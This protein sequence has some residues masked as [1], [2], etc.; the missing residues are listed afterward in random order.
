MSET[1]T[2]S[3]SDFSKIY[4]KYHQRYK[5][6]ALRYVR[7][8]SVAEDIVADSFLTFLENKDSLSTDDNI[9][10]YLFSIVRSK[11]L[12]YLRQEKRRLEI[13]KTIH[14]ARSLTIQDSIRS[15]ELCNPERLFSEEII[16]IV[17]K[18]LDTMP[19]LTRKIYLEIRHKEKTYKEVAKDNHITPRRVN[20]EMCKALE[21]LRLALVDFLCVACFLKCWIAQ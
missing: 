18:S 5:L 16:A 8:V 13:E 17:S 12:N 2:L 21:I 1:N 9:P 14:S 6:L 7:V 15:L 20:Y 10:A 4:L 3:P 19:M 11:S